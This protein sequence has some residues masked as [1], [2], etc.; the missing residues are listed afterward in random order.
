MSRLPLKDRFKLSRFFTGEQATDQPITLNQRRIFILPTQRGLGF[1]V[2]ISLLLLIAFVYSNN[3]AYMLAF[4]LASIFFITILHTYQSLSGLILKEAPS[5]NVFAGEMAE[6]FIQ[7]EN[8]TNK[9][10]HNIQISMER[11]EDLSISAH[12]KAPISLYSSTNQ[13]GWHGMGK[14]TVAS[15]FPFGLFRAWSP[16][17]FNLKILVYPKPATT[18]LPFPETPSAQARQG[19]RKKGSEDYHGLQ[20]YHAGDAIR[21]MDWKTYAK[22]LGLYTKQYGGEQSA[23][24]WLDYDYT[25]GYSREERLSQL[26]R[27]VMDAEQAGISYGF[28]LPGIKRLPDHGL[29]HYRNCLDALALF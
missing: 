21:H 19:L 1:V 16:L 4:L 12:S 22:G 26:C 17:R 3:L 7:I 23:V 2:L 15:T 24:I 18:Q 9:D 5:K 20:P 14:V 10:C 27:W 8:P 29:Q 6:F 11:V 28:S 25:P 13:R